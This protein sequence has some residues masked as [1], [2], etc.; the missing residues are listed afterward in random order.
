MSKETPAIKT[1]ESPVPQ[2]DK[3]RSR[4]TTS[5]TDSEGPSAENGVFQDEI[6][7]KLET[8]MTNMVKTED[9]KEIVTDIVNG[10]FQNLKETISEDIHNEVQKKTSEIRRKIDRLNLE[11]ERLKEMVVQQRK[12]IQTSNA[13]QAT[14]SRLAHQA[15]S[16][17]NYNEQYSRK[18]T[19][20][21]MNMD[22]SIPDQDLE[23][24]FCEKLRQE[25]KIEIKPCEILAC[26][27]IPSK[28]SRKTKPVLVK[29][30]RNDIKHHVMRTRKDKNCRLTL[31][32]REDVTKLNIELIQKLYQDARIESVW[33]FNSRVYGKTLNGDRKMFDIYDNLDDKLTK[34]K[35]KSK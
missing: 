4:I 22:D 3:K 29:F 35:P 21:V 12:E 23:K 20:K 16:M 19:I 9:L 10:I 32:L 31:T 17:A 13:K 7:E 8:I 34:V 24:A 5:S 28:N 11:K 14:S 6:S 15:M 25:A 18:S 33:Y 1:K 30:A 27:R 26:H 2:P